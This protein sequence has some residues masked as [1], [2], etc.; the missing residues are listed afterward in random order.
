MANLNS[1]KVSLKLEDQGAWVPVFQDAEVKL[2][3]LSYP[4]YRDEASELTKPLLKRIRAGSIEVDEL[5]RAV[6]PAFARHIMVDWKNIEGDEGEIEFS[7]EAALE[8]LL[9]PEFKEFYEL[10]WDEAT[11]VENF[12]QARLDEAEGN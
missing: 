4:K 1:M 12:R 5:R 9:K 7:Y 8:I 2:R 10:L 11:A 6:A 3:R